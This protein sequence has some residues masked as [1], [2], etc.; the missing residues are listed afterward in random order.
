MKIAIISDT[1]NLLR[2]E[3]T[4]RIRGA[5]CIL[6]GGDISSQEILDRLEAIAPVRVV[7]GNN[8]KEWAGHLPEFLDFELAGIH[9][10]MTHK[11][12]DLPKDLSPY[13]LVVV[14][15]SHQ[16]SETWKEWPDGRRTLILNPGSCG[17][18]RFFQ[19]ITMALLAVDDGGW[20]VERVEIPHEQAEARMPAPD[21]RT[22]IEA[23][24]SETKKSRSVE[25]IA[26][27]HRLETAL[28]EQIVRLY[29]THPGVTVEGIMTKMG[30]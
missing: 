6:H 5:D 29:V 28:V 4:E 2:Q 26:R 7:R 1:H 24:V 17:P 25:E 20:S 27:K 14:G 30:L 8:D 23:V 10:Y 9:F 21:M 22:V 18:R 19:A 13:D 15:H 11:K 16:Y 12:K 3:E